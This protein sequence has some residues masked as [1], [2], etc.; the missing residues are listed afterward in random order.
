MQAELT[1]AR[2]LAERATASRSTLEE[3]LKEVADSRLQAESERA[4]ALDSSQRGLA[5]ELERARGA[6]GERDMPPA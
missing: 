1:Q 2:E 6:L 4:G 3:E 5:L